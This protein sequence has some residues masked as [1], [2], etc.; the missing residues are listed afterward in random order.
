[1]LGPEAEADL[2]VVARQALD[3]ERL[4]P[5]SAAALPRLAFQVP[6]RAGLPALG[7]YAKLRRPDGRLAVVGATEATRGC[8]HRCRH[9]P[10]VPVYDGQFRVV[11][12]EVVLGRHARAGARPAPS[13]SPSAIPTSST[14]RRT[15]A[16]S[17][18]R[19]TPSG[20]P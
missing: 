17:S 8:K 9:C 13:T 3:G 5:P 10:I 15:P 6:D 19:C 4:A 20:P 16:G 18:R 1:M 2:V 14:A 7:A 12:V 11:P